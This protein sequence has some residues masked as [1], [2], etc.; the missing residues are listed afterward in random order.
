MHIIKSDVG[1]TCEQLSKYVGQVEEQNSYQASQFN[2][3]LLMI[4][5]MVDLLFLECELQ[6]QDE[7]DRH[8]MSL[9]SLQPAKPSDPP[10]EPIREP[11]QRGHAIQLDEDCLSCSLDKYRPTIKQAFKMA[12][13]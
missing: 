6:L 1:I 10:P 5:T 11:Y 9:W 7:A 13:I 12:C 3:L 8:H 4:K 2:K